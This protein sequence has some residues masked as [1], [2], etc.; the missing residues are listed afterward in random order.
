[1]IIC[2][3]NK[4]SLEKSRLKCLEQVLYSMF[5]KLSH[6]IFSHFYLISVLK[7]SLTNIENKSADVYKICDTEIKKYKHLNITKVF[8]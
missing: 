4:K 2:A 5:V 8:K 7:L 6:L 1:M 3:N